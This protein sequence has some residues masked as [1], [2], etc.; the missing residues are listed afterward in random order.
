MAI[1]HLP[2]NLRLLCSYGRSTSDICRRAGINRQQ[3]NKYLNGHAQPSLSSLRRLCDFFGLDDNEILL[4]NDEFRELIRLRPPRLRAEQSRLEKAIETLVSASTTNTSLLEEHEGY[5]HTYSYPD[6]S[7]DIFLRSLACI[8][9]EGGAWLSKSV[10]RHLDALFMLPATLKYRGIVVEGFDRIAIYEREQ[11]VGR[12]VFAT[13]LYT[14][15]RAAPTFLSGLTTG[16]SPEGSHD[17]HCL[18]TVWQ[19][20]GKTP[21]LRQALRSCGAVDQSRETLPDV[22]ISCTD[23]R[24]LEGEAVFAPRF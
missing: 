7:R 2:E 22:I 8:Y 15:E 20:L 13:F 10:E 24:L 4:N 14:A 21:D 5:Y 9:R 19:Y 18:R 1:S 12:S 11:G 6:P 17:V 3:M 23:N 16:F